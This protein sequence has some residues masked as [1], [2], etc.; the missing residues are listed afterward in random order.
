MSDD[1][2]SAS[3]WRYGHVGGKRVAI[4]ESRFIGPLNQVKGG[5]TM[6]RTVIFE[7]DIGF[8]AHLAAFDTPAEITRRNVAAINRIAAW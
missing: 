7:D 2:W 8:R 3:T 6:R 4:G 5:P 1:N